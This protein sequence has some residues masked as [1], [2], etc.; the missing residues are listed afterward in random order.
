[1]QFASP[2]TSIL[3]LRLA[4]RTYIYRPPQ[5]AYWTDAISKTKRETKEVHNVASRDPN[6]AFV[7]IPYYMQGWASCLNPYHYLDQLTNFCKHL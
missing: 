1:M 7:Y 4:L 5:K 6:M 3:R 2:F